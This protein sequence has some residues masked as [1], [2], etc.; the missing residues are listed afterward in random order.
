MY[1][2]Y[3]VFFLI[4]HPRIR[5]NRATVSRFR[6]SFVKKLQLEKRDESD[7]NV[8]SDKSN[9]WSANYEKF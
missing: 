1:I 4:A 5:Q 8:S 7:S 2:L 3:F 9:L 6:F